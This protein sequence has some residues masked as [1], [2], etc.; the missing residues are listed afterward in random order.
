MYKHH[1]NWYKCCKTNII[2][3]A[4]TFYINYHDSYF[5]SL[6]IQIYSNYNYKI[7]YYDNNNNDNNNN[8]NNN[9]DKNN[10]HNNNNDNNNNDNNNND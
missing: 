1:E 8:S 3:S 5:H 7:K 10:N 4:Q 2:T 9:N 6:C